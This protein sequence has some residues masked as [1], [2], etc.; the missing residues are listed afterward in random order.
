MGVE[1]HR[2]GGAATVC[3]G[4]G[5]LF[6]L[7]PGCGKATCHYITVAVFDP[8][9]SHF[10]TDCFPGTVSQA[11]PTCARGEELSHSD[12][13]EIRNYESISALE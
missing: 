3:V 13:N 1:Q 2:R 11:A 5:L 8:N 4:R 6:T 9:N 7:W 12:F 10:H